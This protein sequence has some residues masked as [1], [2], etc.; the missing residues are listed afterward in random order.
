MT[1]GK[2]YVYHK[3]YGANKVALL[4][5]GKETSK[6][7]GNYLDPISKQ[8]TDMECSVFTFLVEPKTKQWQKKINS[9]LESWWIATN[10]NTK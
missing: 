6:S 8:E 7:N 4:Y 9:E 10:Q 3:Y 1:C 5:P 2:M